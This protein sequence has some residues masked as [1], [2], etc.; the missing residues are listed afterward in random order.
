M[1]SVTRLYELRGGRVTLNGSGT[2]STAAGVATRGYAAARGVTYLDNGVA[3]RDAGV[4][5]DFSL[6]HDDLALTRIAGRLLGGGVTGDAEIRNLLSGSTRGMKPSME[7]ATQTR[8]ARREARR[9]ETP[10]QA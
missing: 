1:G 8:E 7:Q 10:Q 3:V 9:E 4:N 6:A 5:A 2:Y